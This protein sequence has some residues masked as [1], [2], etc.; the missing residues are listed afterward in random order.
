MTRSAVVR[1]PLWLIAKHENDRMVVLTIERG[2]DGETLPIFSHEEEAKVFLRLGAPGIAWEV[3]ETTGEELIS[4]LCGPCADVK[5]V[6]LDPL[7]VVGGEMMV[8]LVSLGREN[9]VRNLVGER[10]S[11]AAI[12]TTALLTSLS[13]QDK[14]PG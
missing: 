9:F 12:R 7:P 14:I 6:A 10:E 11:S 2:S 5:K 8:D 3:R 1:R 4:V 13:L